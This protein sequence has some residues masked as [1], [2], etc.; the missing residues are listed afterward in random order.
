MITLLFAEGGQ[1]VPIW[2]P[3]IYYKDLNRCVGV[4]LP[5]LNGLPTTGFLFIYIFVIS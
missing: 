5:P 4:Y 2:L 1:L 3:M